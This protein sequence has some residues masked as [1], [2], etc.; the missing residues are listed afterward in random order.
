ML[1][2]LIIDLKMFLVMPKNYLE[3]SNTA[4]EKPVEQLSER[5]LLMLLYS[6]A[7]EKKL[8]DGK[9]IKIID[10]LL[11][12][13][14]N[15]LPASDYTVCEMI[16]EVSQL[17]KKV[18]VQ[19]KLNTNNIAACYH[20]L[21]VFYI[22]EIRYLNKKNICL[23]PY[24]FSH[25]LYFDNDFVPMDFLFLKLAK[26]YY[27]VS[28]LGCRFRHLQKLLKKTICWHSENLFFPSVSIEEREQV[29]VMQYDRNQR[30]I[31]IQKLESASK[32]TSHWEMQLWHHYYYGFLQAGRLG[33]SSIVILL[34]K[35]TK[36]LQF[37]LGIVLLILEFLGENPYLKEVSF[38]SFNDQQ[39]Q[40]LEELIQ[41]LIRF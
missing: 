31:W 36:N 35:E 27:G 23:C 38:V 40:G 39:Q 29:D 24:C 13:P 18:P 26:L 14:D 37:Y 25:Q 11:K 15:S 8:K 4:A 41:T 19:E 10:L 16:N 12:Y 7:L 22:E 9:I 20:C 5:E 2:E 33:F 32:V 3:V 1:P 17:T 6:I 21:Q 34:P 28:P 30:K